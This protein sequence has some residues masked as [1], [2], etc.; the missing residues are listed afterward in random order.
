MTRSHLVLIAGLAVVVALTTEARA[1]NK[2]F[3]GGLPWDTNEDFAFVDES[4]DPARVVHDVGISLTDAREGTLLNP[5]STLPASSSLGIVNL[6]PDD[7][8]DAG[9]FDVFYTGLSGDFP[10]SSFFDVLFNIIDRG[11]GQPAATN[12]GTVKFFNDSKGFGFISTGGVPG[13]IGYSY[14]LTGEIN[15]AQPGLSFSELLTRR[16]EPGE[17]N[18]DGIDVLPELHFDGSGSID[19]TLP[20][21]R[22]TIASVPEPS[23]VL[24]A[25]LG[26]LSVITSA[27]RRRR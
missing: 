11:T 7:L 12:K 26:A 17:L 16:G 1:G 21:F 9:Y 13:A 14:S 6:G 18:F 20:L 22:I 25:G 23:T 10:T 8:G 4:T 5:G 24:L 2:L 27:R 3:V 19:P 15:P